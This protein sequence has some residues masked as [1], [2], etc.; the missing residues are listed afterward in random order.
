MQTRKG[1]ICVHTGP[2][3]T[4]V[5]RKERDGVYV[6]VQI[7][8]AVPLRI[9]WVAERNLKGNDRRTCDKSLALALS[10]VLTL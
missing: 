10:Q 6:R 9:E 2:G 3:G 5:V 4:R 1:S 8:P 7:L